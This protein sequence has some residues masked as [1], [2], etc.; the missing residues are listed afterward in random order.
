MR[1]RPYSVVL[2][3]EFEKAH[4][5]VQSMFLSL[6]DEGLL[7]DSEGRKVHAREAWFILTTNLS[8]ADARARLGFGSDSAEARRE[9]ALDRVRKGFR[10]ELL[11]RLDETVVFH[12]LGLDE[13]ELVATHHLERLAERA[14]E[15]G[16]T[17]TWDASVP[18][19]V[20][21]QDPDP[22]GGARATLRAL[23]AL[24]AVP[25]ADA[26]I[27]GAGRALKATMRDGRIQLE[28]E[29]RPQRLGRQSA[30]AV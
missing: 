16:I 5:D 6:F 2:L 19:F 10:P 24:V 12:A 30:P 13:L 29:G 4:G 8:V 28:A 1:R 27:G 15:Q 22:S 21:R 7:T 20:A 11:Q 23:E 17:L 18:S 26:M 14:L 25:L 3:D 9:A